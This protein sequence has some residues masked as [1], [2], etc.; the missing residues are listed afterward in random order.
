MTRFLARRLLIIPPNISKVRGCVRA[1][2]LVYR[3][4]AMAELG[5]RWRTFLA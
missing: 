4:G 2:S 5:P 3:A 1:M